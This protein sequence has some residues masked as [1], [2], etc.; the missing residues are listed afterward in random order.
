MTP[1]ILHFTYSE[2]SN[3]TEDFTADIVGMGAFGTV[4]KAKIRGNGP[5]AIKKLHNVRLHTKKLCT[6]L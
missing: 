2:L 6:D 5:F 3:E 1:N 4:F